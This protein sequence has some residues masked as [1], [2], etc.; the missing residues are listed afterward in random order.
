MD[1]E[2]EVAKLHA[3]VQ[4]HLAAAGLTNAQ[5]VA[6]CVAPEY[7]SRQGG[8][9]IEKAMDIVF[10]GTVRE[11]VHAVKPGTGHYADTVAFFRLCFNEA[12]KGEPTPSPEAMLI[13]AKDP[14][15]EEYAC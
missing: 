14:G 10:V 5:R 4:Q 6:T 15:A 12:N 3:G 11:A 7:Y 2:A 9:V 1:F 13:E 8:T